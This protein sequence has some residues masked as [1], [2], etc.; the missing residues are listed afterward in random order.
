MKYLGI[1][2][3]DK[4]KIKLHGKTKEFERLSNSLVR[5][6]FS[7]CVVLVDRCC[8]VTEKGC[9]SGC[10]QFVLYLLARGEFEE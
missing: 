3:N 2:F 5:H 7:G 4:L 1:N 8:Y 9:V 10:V 6:L